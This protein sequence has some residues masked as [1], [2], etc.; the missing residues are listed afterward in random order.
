MTKVRLPSAV[1]LFLFA[2]FAYIATRKWY[3]DN[4]AIATLALIVSFLPFYGN[5]K[6][7][8]GE[9]AGLFFL[10]AG[11]LFLENNNL[12]K[13]FLSGLFL[14]LSVATKPFFLLVLPA[15]FTGEIYR[16]FAQEKRKLPEY[17]YLGLGLF[18]PILIWFWTINPHLNFSNVTTA[19]QYYSNSYK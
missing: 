19:F 18:I 2:L 17:F 13:I 8:L 1:Y 6:S 10:L 7:A 9:V 12:K 3:G 15:L 11:L 16:F 14:G 4:A 5:G